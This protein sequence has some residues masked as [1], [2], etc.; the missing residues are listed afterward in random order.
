MSLEADVIQIVSQVIK[1]P[2]DSLDAK[3]G[4][5][6]VEKWDS[7]NHVNVVLELEDAFDVSFDFDELDH[8]ITI[9]AIVLSLEAKGVAR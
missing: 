8:I 3:C 7:L 1:M 5:D 9:A 2:V 6:N 4:L